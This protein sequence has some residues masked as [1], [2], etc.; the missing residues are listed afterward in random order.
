MLVA[1]GHKLKG[2]ISF[3][4]LLFTIDSDAIIFIQMSLAYRMFCGYYRNSNYVR[5]WGFI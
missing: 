3:H 5:K 1:S 2:P 4:C